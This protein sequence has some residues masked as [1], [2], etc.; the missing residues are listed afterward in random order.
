MLLQP[1]WPLVEY[2]VNYDYISTVLCENRDVPEMQCNGKCYL[3]KMLAK[4][5]Q[6]QDKNPFET[7][8]FK[9]DRLPIILFEVTNL[10]LSAFEFGDHDSKLEEQPSNL[11][12]RL[13]VFE[14][15]RPPEA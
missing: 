1:L 8:L 9:S 3:S 5:K 15:I 7:S 13:F 4:E 11:Y 2:V 14:L 10:N 6:Q 12:D